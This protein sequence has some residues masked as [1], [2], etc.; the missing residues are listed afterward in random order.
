[1]DSLEQRR[2]VVVLGSGLMRDVDLQHLAGR[3]ET[4]LLVDAVHLPMIRLSAR[5]YPN[6][7]LL[8]RDLTGLRVWFEGGPPGRLPPLADLGAEQKVDL[9]ISAN[10][11]SQLP[12]GVEEFMESSAARGLSLPADLP[13]RSVAWHLDDLAAF[14]GKV[15]LITDTVM[16]ERNRTGATI[17]ELDLLRGAHVPEPEETWWWTVAP[18][19]EIERDHESVH[20]V[21]AWSAFKQ[22]S[23]GKAVSL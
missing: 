11:L 14:R 20:K 7:S 9:V 15:C 18:F 22:A 16:L 19:G 12:L 23:S 5:R 2:T 6:V 1:M 17:D 13:A 4:V 3:F 21:C 10:C 8:E